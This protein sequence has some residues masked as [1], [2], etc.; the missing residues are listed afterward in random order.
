MAERSRPQTD[1]PAEPDGPRQEPARRGRPRLT[2]DELQARIQTYCRRYAVSV[3]DQGLPPFPAGRRESAQHREWM[4]LY[5]AQRRIANRA[6]TPELQ[7]RTRESL[8]AQLGRCVVCRKALE[9][10]DARLDEPD[11]STQAPAALHGPCLQLV[12]LARALG[13]EAVDRARQRS[14]QH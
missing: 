6:P 3:N 14:E 9:L 10:A 7:V 1:G 5:K 4:S 11:G 12:E 13:P 8:A 2:A